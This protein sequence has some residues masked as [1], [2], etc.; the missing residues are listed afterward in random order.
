MNSV[1]VCV[2]VCV[3]HIFEAN[4]VYGCAG[5]MVSQITGSNP[6]TALSSLVCEHTAMWGVG[7][8]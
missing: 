5:R 1:C 6:L 3:L 8:S 7:A 2:C 4:M